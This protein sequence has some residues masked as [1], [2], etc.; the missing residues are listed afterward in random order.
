MATLKI[1]PLTR[2]EGHGRIELDL[3]GRQV[4]AVRVSLNEPTRLFE[5]LLIGR[6]WH[7]VPAL[8]C[9][10][11]SI[12]SSVHRIAAAT[13]MEEA[14]RVEIPPRARLLRELLLLGGQIESHSLHLFAL[15][16]PD[17]AGVTSLLD[18]LR[19][20]GEEAA[21]GLELKRLGNRI[22]E[23]VGG[24]MIHPVTVEV[25]GMGGAPP[26]QALEELLIELGPWRRSA[27]ELLAVFRK[28]ESYPA[29]TLPLGTRLRAAKGASSF[30][31]GLLLADGESLAAG[32]YRE[33]L[34][35][36][37][38]GYSRAKQAHGGRGPFLTG[39]MARQKLGEEG[40]LERGWVEQVGIH[41]ANALR[42]I[43]LQQGLSQAH[44]VIEQ[45]LT[46]GDDGPLK[47]HVQRD[48][49][50]GTAA[51][52]APRGLLIHHYVLDTCGR[53]AAADIVTPTAINQ[54]VMEQQ[55]LSDLQGLEDEEEISLRAERIIRAYDPC[56]SCA[57]HLLQK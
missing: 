56:I 46:L 27:G 43:E 2:V 47:G 26:R 12:C 17:I 6:E 18:L 7:E 41:S 36:T 37:T 20:G 5:G 21:R 16:L 25:G 22:Q 8:A 54:M 10:I 30:G 9:R 32:E 1:D 38:V 19:Q 49:G 4:V 29:A 57:V 3:D 40:V 11:C 24:R 55:L 53:V 50:V 42:A 28:Q 52:E 51:F 35:E 31:G 39:P 23:V 44:E 13:A 45:L 33:L 14:L 48:A 15:I 34:Q